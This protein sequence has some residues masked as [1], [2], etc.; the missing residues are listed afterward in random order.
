MLSVRRYDYDRRLLPNSYLAHLEPPDIRDF[1]A[2]NDR[3]GLTPGYPAWNLL[4]YS[5]FCSLP[6]ESYGS[7]FELSKLRQDPV[8]VETGT[9]RGA[10]TIV[11]AQ[12]LKDAGLASKVLTVERREHLQRVA[13]K[14]VEAAGLSSH[15]TFHL[16]DSVEF[17]RGL[18]SV[19]FLFLDDDHDFEHVM[20]EIEAI[21]D[22]LR[23][24]AIVYFDNTL[25]GGVAEALQAIPERYGGNVIEFPN[26]SLGPPGNA[27]WQLKAPPQA[28]TAEAEPA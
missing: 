7:T 23:E 13:R 2:S 21:H 14:H 17:L 18:E 1:S 8:V 4:Y 27:I 25:E 24:G 11:M 10:S 26:C 28:G 20:T 3:T 15:V 5:L 19:D 9:N 22:K 12:A 6:V 16:G